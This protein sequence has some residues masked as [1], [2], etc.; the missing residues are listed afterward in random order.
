MNNVLHSNRFKAH[1]HS[2]KQV[3]YDLALFLAGVSLTTAVPTAI[4]I[5]FGGPVPFIVFAATALIGIILG[6]AN[7]LYFPYQVIS[8]V[9]T[10]GPR[11]ASSTTGTTTTPNAGTTEK[12][13]A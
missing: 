2:R 13:A 5:A 1:P 9:D 7:Y 11:R 4:Y 3:D 12:K 6:L 10:K 8:C